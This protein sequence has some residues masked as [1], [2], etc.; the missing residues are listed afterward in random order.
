MPATDPTTDTTAAATAVAA[1][2]PKYR[3]LPYGEKQGSFRGVPACSNRDDGFF[4]G[5]N[6]Y[7]D[8]TIYTGFRY[9]CVEYAR[10]FL[11]MTTGCVFSECGRASEVFAKDSIKH[12]ETGESYPLVAHQNGTSTTRPRAGDVIIHPYED[13]LCPWGHIGIVSYVDDTRIGVAEQN[14]C[15]GSFVSPRADYE[16]GERCVARFLPLGCDPSTGAWTITEG[17]SMPSPLGWMSYVTAPCRD[18]VYA[19][20]TPL[21]DFVAARGTDPSD[22]K[23]SFTV[24]LA[25]PEPLPLPCGSSLTHIYGTGRGTGESSVGVATAMSRVLRNTL[26]TLFRRDHSGEVF[27]SLPTNPLGAESPATPPSAALDALFAALCSVGIDTVAGGGVGGPEEKLVAAVAAY[28][29]LSERVVAAMQKE[30]ARGELHMFADLSLFLRHA[31]AER[32]DPT[33]TTPPR[34][35]GGYPTD[36]TWVVGKANFG[37]CTAMLEI[38][39]LGEQMEHI[40]GAIAIQMPGFRGFGLPAYQHD[41]T[42]YLKAVEERR[43]PRTAFTIALPDADAR[44]PG[45]VRELAR[46]LQTYCEKIKYPVRIVAES[47]LRYDAATGK[48]RAVISGDSPQPSG[49]SPTTADTPAG[50][51]DIDFVFA[52]AEWEVILN[53]VDAAEVERHAALR[54]AALDH[55]RSDVVFAKPLWSY[56]V[57]GVVNRSYPAGAKGDSSSSTSSSPSD[58]PLPRA[59]RFFDIVR[60]LYHYAEP[61]QKG[62]AWDIEVSE[63]KDSCRRVGLRHLT[64]EQPHAGFVVTSVV[65][66]FAKSAAMAHDGARLVE[67]PRG[68]HPEY[69]GEPASM[70]HVF[71]TEND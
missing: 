31:E 6:N 17:D 3:T 22:P 64:P 10:R 20:F 39:Q 14:Q 59:R 41:F 29:D 4:S 40:Q 55:E 28:F 38:V 18:N 11:L 2:V 23:H 30:F 51:F 54:E 60:R 67:D 37:T 56:L 27:L 66:N 26:Q 32:T 42:C 19:P 25:L 45:P 47:D 69:C 53:G 50:D 12:V 33:V 5:E 63:F 65:V 13:G 62:R 52:I 46:T 57:N 44:V 1:A 68:E 35:P 48:L 61:P 15:F 24:R 36:E 8:H 49:S 9:Q 70:L 16:G 7:V 71:S 34:F 43:G 58:A 21:P